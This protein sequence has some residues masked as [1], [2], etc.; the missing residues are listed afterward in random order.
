MIKGQDDAFPIL[1]QINEFFMMTSV[2]CDLANKQDF[3]NWRTPTGS[4][5]RQE[6]REPVTK[7][8]RTY[9]MGG[10][11]FHQ[12]VDNGAQAHD[13]DTRY[14]LLVG[15]GDVIESKTASALA[16][17]WTHSIDASVAVVAINSFDKPSAFIHDCLVARPGEA[18]EFQKNIQHAYHRCI[19]ADVFEMLAEQNNLTFEQIVSNIPEEK[20]FQFGEVNIDDCLKSDYIFS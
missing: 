2:S 11:N 4:L 1:E 12:F 19:S 13:R 20:R 3:V 16:A 5:I 18:F 17:N 14:E 10:G 15:Y 7:Q 6:Y 8:V 9:A